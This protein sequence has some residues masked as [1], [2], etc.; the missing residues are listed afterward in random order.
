VR[1]RGPQRFKLEPGLE[2]LGH[3]R[4]AAVFVANCDPYTYAGA[5]PLHV[6]PEARFELGLDLVAPVSMSP[7]SLPR[8]VRYVLR[9]KG[10]Q[11]AADVL[12]AHDVDRIEITCDRP[13]PL[14]A[15]GED[16]G[17]VEHVVLEAERDA[18]DLLV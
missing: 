17:D 6:A 3:G 9:G 15:D 13:L 12:Y 11:S 2:V 4:A 5:I 7:R 1:A 8:L 16:L 10:Q 18:I 14:Q